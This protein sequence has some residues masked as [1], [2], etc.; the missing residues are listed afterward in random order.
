[1]SFVVQNGPLLYF[2]DYLTFK[3]EVR[4]CLCYD[5]G[6]KS[7]LY[8]FCTAKLNISDVLHKYQVSVDITMPLNNTQALS[9]A[10]RIHV[11]RSRI[12]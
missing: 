12:C 7:V 10:K 8:D 9:S 2:M 11:N 3:L 6:E 1:M 5:D 4:V